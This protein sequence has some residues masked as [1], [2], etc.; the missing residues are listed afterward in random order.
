MDFIVDLPA[1]SG[2]FDSILTVVDRFTKRAHFIPTTKTVSA[3]EV[4]WLF[5]S[6]IYVHH[7]LPKS[8]ISDRDP[9]FT[10]H[11]W[12][13]VFKHLG[14]TLNLS[15]AYHP[16]T[17]GQSERANRTVKDM[18]RHFVHPLHDD[19]DRY[20]PVIEFA[21][22]N[23][24]SPS[25]RHTPF[26]LEYGRHPLTPSSWLL[27]SRVPK[28]DDFLRA[29]DVAHAAARAAISPD[30]LAAPATHAARLQ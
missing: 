18:L 1:T 22:N 17:D 19:W 8:I 14:T 25:T 26:F 3:V 5:I 27:E 29:I 2:G 4:A 9:K 23:S 20:L 12:P 24:V 13:T 30:H 11:F 21:Y 6:H 15:T 28:A 16:Q 10:S 7:G